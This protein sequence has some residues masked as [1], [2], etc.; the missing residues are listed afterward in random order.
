M[1]LKI[2]DSWNPRAWYLAILVA[3]LN[4]L[5]ASSA[6]PARD[7]SSADSPMVRPAPQETTAIR[8][9]PTLS[10]VP[11]PSRAETKSQTRPITPVIIARA[12]NTAASGA[13]KGTKLHTSARSP[14]TADNAPMTC[15]S[16]VTASATSCQ[17]PCGSRR[18]S[19]LIS[20][21]MADAAAC[22]FSSRKV[23]AAWIVFM[24]WSTV[25]SSFRLSE[26]RRTTVGSV[27]PSICWGVGPSG[28]RAG[29]PEFGRVSRALPPPLVLPS[30][31]L[32]VAAAAAAAVCIAASIW[33]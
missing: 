18:P 28:E 12:P 14:N 8:S 25:E 1:T 31:A 21:S 24:A 7:A 4:E 11:W 3:I 2:V 5:T 30:L 29:V 20:D 10:Q 26:R 27:E 32:A 23:M 9:M 6:S 22:A 16:S 15:P 19:L 33:L 17:K 13:R